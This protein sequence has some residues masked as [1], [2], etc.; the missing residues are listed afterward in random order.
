MNSVTT[1]ILTRIAKR[2]AWNF[3][4]NR[5]LHQRQVLLAWHRIMHYVLTDGIEDHFGVL[6]EMSQDAHDKVWGRSL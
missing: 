2:E 4:R 1:W 3:R 5:A 6:K